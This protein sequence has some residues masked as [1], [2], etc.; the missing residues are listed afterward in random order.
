MMRFYTG[1]LSTD[2]YGTVGLII[3]ACIIIMAIVSLSVN[4]SLIRFGLDN[5][6]D[7]AQVFS[8]GLSTVLGGLAVFALIAPFLNKITMF[9]GY[10]VWIYFYVFCGSIKSC[11]S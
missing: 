2:G 11:C 5:K 3:D 10:A 6:Y 4:E 1:M 8:I 9:E 7:K